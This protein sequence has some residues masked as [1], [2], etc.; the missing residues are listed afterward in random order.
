M[1]VDLS[2][3]VAAVTVYQSGALVT[4][5]AELARG[6]EGFAARVQLV[7]LPLALDDGSV[8]VE[9][10]S[11]GEGSELGA[12]RAPI[13]GG[14]RV[15]L[16]APGLDDRLA[17]PSD[18][19]LD[20]ARLELATIS[21]ERA[22]IEAAIAR[23]AKLEPLARGA[24]AK[25]EAPAPSPTKARLELLEFRRDR[26]A[27]LAERLLAERERERIAREQV[28]ELEE[29]ARLASSQRNVRTHE[30]RK[31]AILEL[32]QGS[33]SGLA[34]RATIRLHYFVPGAR[35]APTYTLRLEAGMRAATL[36]LRALVGQATGEDWDGVAL[37][38]STAHPQRWTDLPKLDSQRIG[39]RQPS[40]SKTGWRPPPSGAEALYADYDRGLGPPR[41]PETP[42]AAVR[43]PAAAYEQSIELDSPIDSP[44]DSP[45]ADDAWRIP[46]PQPASAP[47]PM[48]GPPGMPPA[49]SRGAAPMPEFMPA[50]Q[51]MS[52][53]K[54]SRGIGSLVGG[55]V[56]AVSSAFGA[57]PGGSGGV[58]PPTEAEAEAEPELQAS[59]ELLD[60]GRLRLFEAGDA[61]R[62]RLRRISERAS[63]QH[64]SGAGIEI[65]AALTR[66]HAALASARELDDQPAPAGHRWPTSEGGYD[67]AYV[68]N[69]PSQ[70]RS[71]GRFHAILLD[72]RPA[73]VAP[74]YVTV[75]RVTQDVFR[76]VRL[77]NPL[78]APLLPG[79]AD[80]YVAGKFALTTPIELTPIGGRLELGLGVEQ[81]IKVARNVTYV[82]DS[83]G[84]FK[85]SL[86]LR[87][88]VHVEIANHLSAA[89]TV[90]VRERVPVAAE[91]A[92]EDIRVEIAERTPAWEDWQPKDQD[93]PLRGG[94]RWIV[95]VAA[96][97]TREL[98][99]TWVVTIP[100]GHE[101]V[102]GNR[103]E[104]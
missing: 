93:P 43:A 92:A 77:H 20:R 70:L 99:V 89:A 72:T 4:R 103:R 54:R 6:P 59:D 91:R 86:E 49:P 23:I 68:A 32:E 76:I 47:P 10:T 65:E 36:E 46:P 13:A 61:R 17:P 35:W 50:T 60:Y 104:S 74:R 51:S 18:E 55:A 73:E 57:A 100:T 78:A 56:D 2:S 96:G 53:P 48:A 34:E 14:L 102:G 75:P 30:L 29:R 27:A 88:T 94:H 71:D 87:H 62:G 40:A 11:A 39:R 98:A 67:Y 41:I 80:V 3:E 85:R 31:A 79:P 12:G 58:A 16:A 22:Q 24:A 19:E 33:D 81:A 37:T 44:V 9:V 21:A 15:A 84:M 83:S 64:S 26:S 7:G 63:Y 82:E 28:A 1:L 42:I 25:G 5:V 66:I 69:G 97:A 101:L 8:R 45:V 95:E 90:E 38:L 52:M